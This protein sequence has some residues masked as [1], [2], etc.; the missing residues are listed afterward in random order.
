[1]KSSRAL[2]VFKESPFSSI[3]VIFGIIGVL[4]ILSVESGLIEGSKAFTYDSEQTLGNNI[5]LIIGLLAAI[6]AFVSFFTEK[7][8]ER[9]RLAFF[10]AML[11]LMWYFAIIMIV[12]IVLYALYENFLG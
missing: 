5:V 2:E 11:P 12:L 3:A 4:A 9:R 8:K 7:K 6:F 1:M 10:A